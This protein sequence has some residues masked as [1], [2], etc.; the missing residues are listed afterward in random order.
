MPYLHGSIQLSGSVFYVSQE[1]WLFPATV[2]DNILFGKAYEKEKFQSIIKCCFLVHDLNS[3]PHAENTL[4]GDKG[5]NLSGGQRARVGLARALYSDAQIYLLDD[6]LAAVDATV[7][8][9]L[10]DRCINGYLKDKI[11]VFV[12]HH[13][14]HLVKADKVM[15]L[16]KGRILAQGSFE[17][18]SK[19]DINLESLLAASI[20]RENKNISD[21]AVDSMVR[22]R[23]SIQTNYFG[24]VN[25]MELNCSGLITKVIILDLRSSINFNKCSFELLF[26]ESK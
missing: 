10:F 14:H 8:K 20:E 4:I 22:R 17:E 15:V 9:Y 25:A 21:P 18:V 7:A 12:T 16:E 5:S 3:L 19:L 2:K 26:S 6:P 1:P 13:M 23:S 24:S 11:R